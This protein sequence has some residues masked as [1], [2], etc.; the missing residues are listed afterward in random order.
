MVG[1]PHRLLLPSLA[2]GFCRYL[3]RARDLIRKVDV[4]GGVDQVQRVHFP[5]VDVVP[6]SSS[7]L[8]PVDPSFRAL[9]GSPK[10]TVRRHKSN[11]DSLPLP[12]R[13]LPC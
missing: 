3:Q 7:H 9:S 6:V 1:V 13:P 4:P 11:T 10:F 8:G 2:T 12:D 5:V